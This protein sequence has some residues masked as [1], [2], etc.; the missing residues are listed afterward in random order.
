MR[1][2]L[3]SSRV[4]GKVKE[5]LRRPREEGPGNVQHPVPTARH[6]TLRHSDGSF[7]STDERKSRKTC[8]HG[9]AVCL[10]Y[11]PPKTHDRDPDVQQLGGKQATVGLR[12]ETQPHF[13]FVSAGQRSC[14]AAA[15][16]G[17]G[18][19][20]ESADSVAPR[21]HC[22][23]TNYVDVTYFKPPNG[24]SSVSTC[25]Y[26]FHVQH[27]PPEPPFRV[28]ALKKN[29]L[30][31]KDIPLLMYHCSVISEI[32]RPIRHLEWVWT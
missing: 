8:R 26:F 2:Y 16:A 15:P 12:S 18:V 14:D 31:L 5:P 17:G 32:K 24:L 21:H 10:C 20:E 29:Y 28:T 27:N 25:S 11:T 4:F 13:L 1:P 7:E 3:D 30:M 19:V 22:S 23:F 6:D 9:R